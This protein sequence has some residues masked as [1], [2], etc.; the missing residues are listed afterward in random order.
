MFMRK[1]KFRH[2]FG[3]ALKRDQCYDNIRITKSSWDSR[4]CDVNPK[5][6]AVIT[7]A[8]GGGSFLVLPLSKVGRVERDSPLVAGHKAAVL[9]ISWCPHNDDVIA[10]AS[11]DCTIKIW[12]IP[13]GG[14]TKPLTEPVVDLVAHQ[15]RVS[16]V[17]WHPT[18]HNVLLSAGSDNKIFIWNV[19]TGEV[20]TEIDLPDLPL[21]AS[22][23]FNGSKF[24]CTCKDKKLRVYNSRSGEC[25]QEEP[26]HAGAKPAQVVYLKDGLIFT[27]G[28]SRM[29]ERQ[30]ALWDEKDLS[31]AKEMNELDNSNGVM[32]PMYD[33]DVNMVYL[34]GKGDSQIRYFEVTDE[35]PYVHYLNTYQSKEAGRGVG[36]M[37]KR[38]LNVNNCEIAR[39]YKLHNSGLCEVIPFTVPRK[40]ELF[41]DDLYPDTPSD[42]PA[43][44]AEE[45]F[46][47]KDAEPIMVSLK[48]G[49]V[50]TRKDALK[51]VRRSNVLDKMPT[52]TSQA[53]ST[54]S[55]AAAAPVL[56]PKPSTTSTPPDEHVGFDPQGILDD[57]RK[58]KLIVKAHE[59][60]I[61][62]LEEKLSQYEVNTSEEDEGKA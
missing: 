2:V 48:G 5:Y 53:Q 19:G 60:R 61:K 54:N 14:L 47:G 41:Q 30:Y 29:S 27:T 44:S 34:C 62:T 46:G 32:F 39:I 52:R 50:P 6:V 20:F 25:L 28:F 51:V 15:R 12:Q 4:Y 35:E 26:G 31:K 56:P 57:M 24:A 42:T 18:A 17:K 21:S 13:E 16:C 33:A 11:E 9:D 55:E 38:G 23:N 3:Q 36:F 40:S 49:F 7:E 8:A 45:W 1:S 37:S 58:L 22:F 59:R 43:L 10:S